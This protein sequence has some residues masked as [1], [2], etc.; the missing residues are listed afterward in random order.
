[1]VMIIIVI[2]A[3]ITEKIFPT[4]I[5]GG[6]CQ[7]ADRYDF[8][9]S[10]LFIYRR[11]YLINFGNLK[12]FGNLKFVVLSLTRIDEHWSPVVDQIRNDSYTQNSA[13]TRNRFLF[14]RSRRK[15]ISKRKRTTTTQQRRCVV[16]VTVT[17][18]TVHR[19]D[20]ANCQAEVRG[21]ATATLAYGGLW[22]GTPPSR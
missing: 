10:P 20:L 5:H 19:Q 13:E 22:P 15:W 2:F 9:K 12:R 21:G 4:K 18:V 17:V 14:F 8:C 7:A 1:M 3:R 16:G 6:I 11:L